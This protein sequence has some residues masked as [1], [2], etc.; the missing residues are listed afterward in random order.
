MISNTCQKYVFYTVI[1]ALLSFGTILHILLF[2][3]TI[4][5]NRICL[6]ICAHYICYMQH[7][8]VIKIRL[9]TLTMTLTVIIQKDFVV[10]L[11]VSTARLVSSRKFSSKIQ[12][13]SK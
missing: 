7:T 2:K 11:T 6:N 10:I 12:F 9:I 13:N 4:E 1:K 5:Y 8:D 3:S